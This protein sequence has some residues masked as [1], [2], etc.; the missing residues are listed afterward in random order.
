MT[1]ELPDLGYEYDALEPFIDTRTMKI[2][3]TKHHQAYVDKL[4]NAVKGTEWENKDIKE[5][6]T[7]LNKVPEE[8]RKA[9]R[10]HGGGHFNHSMF[11]KLLKKQVRFEG[12][13]ADAIVKKWGSLENFKKEFADAANS[14]FGSGWAWLVLNKEDELEI[15]STANQDCPLSEGKQPVIA[16][17]VWEHSYYL[18]YEWRRT[19]YVDAFFNIIN[20]EKANENYN[21]ALKNK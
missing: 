5:L 16:L 4:N 12:K 11:W 1:F 19:E 7:N 17:D 18:K 21:E 9:V 8:I 13:I 14:R 2:H 15:T 3:H 6:I 10:N 20:W